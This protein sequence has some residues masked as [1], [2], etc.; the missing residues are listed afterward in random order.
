MALALVG[1]SHR[2]A[3][4]EVRERLA[5]P[6]DEVQLVL[7]ALR[8]TGVEEVVLL[9][10]CNRTEFYLHPDSAAVLD[11][12]EVVLTEWAGPLPS[13]LHQYLYRCTGDEVPLH[14]FRVTAGLDSMV[15]GE[16]EVQGQV[17]AAYRRSAEA[18]PTRTDAVLNRLFQ[19]ALSVGGRV[20]S[21]TS[22]GEGTVSVASAAVELA[23]KIFGDLGGRQILVLG[24]GDTSERV[25][26]ALG[27]EGVEGVIV[28]SRTYDRALDL[29][30]RL[31][32]RAVRFEEIARALAE[33]DIVLT[34]TSAPHPL[35]TRGTI[36]EAFPGGLSRALLM[37][38]IAIPRDVEP[39][40]GALP[41][42]FLY[43]VDDLQKM[44]D[45]TL[46]RRRTAAVAAE[47]LVLSEAQSFSNWQ[48]SLTVVPAIRRMRER[49]ERIRAG[50]VERL[51][52]RLPHLGAADRAAL[53]AFSRRLMNQLLHDPTVRLREAAEEGRA[54]EMVDVVRSLSGLDSR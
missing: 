36:A 23:R 14:L 9:A 43:N 46:D 34:S 42:V 38:D 50:E 39:E 4:V 27:R 21:E 26:A 16:A 44:L 45:E 25:M 19:T 15:L 28:A 52:E 47:D 20:R 40:V 33:C 1:L 49:G 7:D 12:V 37:V 5:F 17:R 51:I 13:P 31:S 53:E 29:T 32:G 54:E 11:R 2:T 18:D 24:A 30:D 48:R 6:G 35:I 3:P 8:E 22:L 41:N 10:T